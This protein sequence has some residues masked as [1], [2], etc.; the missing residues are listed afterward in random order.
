MNPGRRAAD[1]QGLASGYLRWY[2]GNWALGGQAGIIA[3][4]GSQIGIGIAD[5][6]IGI[7]IAA[8]WLIAVAAWGSPR[9]IG[10]EAIAGPSWL[11]ALLPLLV[12]AALVLRRRAP[13]AMWLAIWAGVALLRLIAHNSLQGLAF[14]FVLLG[15]A[16]SLGAHASSA[17]RSSAFSSPPRSCS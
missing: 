14:T 2:A 1:A 13:L 15:A 7:G 10:S 9:L 5:A 8:A 6:G 3:D 11:L 17:V 4:A 12:G 16:Y